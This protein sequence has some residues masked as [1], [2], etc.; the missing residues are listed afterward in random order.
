LPPG[1]FAGNILGW[2]LRNLSHNLNTA[3]KRMKALRFRLIGLPKRVVSHAGK[4][5]N[6]PGVGAGALALIVL[7]RQ[8]IRA[9]ACGPFG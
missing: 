6:R 2:A 9:R 3:T 1:L 4:L 8:S 7:A 5:I